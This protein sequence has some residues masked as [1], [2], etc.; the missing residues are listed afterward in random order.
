M[1]RSPRSRSVPGVGGS[2]TA[3]RASVRLL[4]APRLILMTLPWVAG[5]V[6]LK[7]AFEA[8]GLTPF[9]VNPLLAG[10][11]SAEVFLLGFLLA[12][13][14][15]DYKESE[16]LPGELAMSLETIGDDCLQSAP[17]PDERACVIHAASL[18][19][20]VREWLHHERHLESVLHDV[21]RLGDYR[22]AAG[23]LRGEQAAIRRVILRIDA[24]RRTS[25][26][27]AGY[28]I[29]ELSAAL[30]VLGLMLTD[31]G[32]LDEAAF[33]SGILTLLLAYLFALIRDLDDPFR[34]AAGREG[35]ADVS[36]EPLEETERRLLEELAAFGVEARSAAPRV[37]P[38]AANTLL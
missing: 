32:P 21:R 7:V 17:D 37:G 6:A 35:A 2:R 38:E 23:R 34:Y 19:R 10:L 22:G 18:A 29:A 12:G 36:L 25:F 26:V 30:L 4:S 20:G 1:T 8:A 31:L 33:F 27:A 5:V 3:R 11:V 9:D 13:T 15:G 14:V 16:K 24:I 28:A